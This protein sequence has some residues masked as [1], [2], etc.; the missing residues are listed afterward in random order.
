MTN[1][2]Q[3][4]IILASS[5]ATRQTMLR[6]AGVE[7]TAQAADLPEA[8]MML[9]WQQK[10]IPPTTVARDLAI[11]KAMAISAQQPD[12]LV[13]GADQMLICGPH[14]LSK[15]TGR[16]DAKNHLRL[17]A[18]KTHQ[19]ITGTALVRGGREL[20]AVTDTADIT[21]RDLDDAAI[22]S[23][24]SRVP[25]SV[26]HSVGCYQFEGLGAQ[27]I[28]SYRGDYFT[29]LGLCLLPLLAAL[30]GQGVRF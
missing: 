7:F 8:Q 26:L 29:I 27:L 2:R 24:I 3:P 16:D 14:W 25:E 19:L 6:H 10:K 22:D 4:M 18:G 9:D 5:S 28:A 1:N 17:L 13:I 12:A 15:A 21:L 11:A 30:R 23:Y 20:W